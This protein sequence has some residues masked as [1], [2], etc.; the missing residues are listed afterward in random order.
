MAQ[1]QVYYEDLSLD[2]IILSN[3]NIAT[4]IKNEAIKQSLKMLLST[5]QGT[6][7]F[8]PDYGC[9]VK[10]FLFEPFDDSTAKRLGI[11]IEESIRNYEPRVTV[12]NVI[13]EMDWATT[14]YNVQI[15]YRVRNTQ[16]VDVVNFDLV[17]L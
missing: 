1:Q 2:P 7:L 15:L 11:E 12:I 13:V 9:R 17:K 10:G 4:K 14:T 6:R 16:I 8:L 3:G 5:G